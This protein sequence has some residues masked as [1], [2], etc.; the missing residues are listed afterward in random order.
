MLENTYICNKCNMIRQLQNPTSVEFVEIHEYLRHCRL[1]SGPCA[2]PV[3]RLK[4]FELTL[5][6][7]SSQSS[8]PRT[9]G[10]WRQKAK[11]MS[12]GFTMRYV[13]WNMV[14]GRQCALIRLMV[15]N[16]KPS[17]SWDASVA[18]ILTEISLCCF[19]KI[20]WFIQCNSVFISQLLGRF[21][22]SVRCKNYPQIFK[23][24]GRLTRGCWE[25]L[26]RW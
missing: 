1:L 6:S 21:F 19:A 18:R 10:P 25:E 26:W 3:G 4:Y 23:W 5:R 2:L 16:Y 17:G 7:S 11:W 13:F 20:F 14:T 24:F 12:I 8:Y 9:R 15:E 22:L